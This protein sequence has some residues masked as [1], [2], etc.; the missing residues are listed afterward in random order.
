MILVFG[1]VLGSVGGACLDDNLVGVDDCDRTLAIALLTIGCSISG[2]MIVGS[3][4]WWLAVHPEFTAVHRP[5]L[6]LALVFLVP[7]LVMG[8]IGTA[9]L[10]DTLVGYDRG[11]CA[12]VLGVVLMVVGWSLSVGVI[13]ATLFFVFPQHRRALRLF[14]VGVA[15]FTLQMVGTACLQ[16]NLVGVDNCS[17]TVAIGFITV[18]SG[19]MAFILIIA[20]SLYVFRNWQGNEV[21]VVVPSL[22]LISGVGMGS[23]GWSCLVDT[24]AGGCNKAVGVVFTLVGWIAV[25]LIYLF[26]ACLRFAENPVRIAQAFIFAL[27]LILGSIGIAC[28]KDD[29]YGFTAGSSDPDGCSAGWGGRLI[30]RIG[31]RRHL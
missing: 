13:L 22:I 17:D 15:A 8:S 2:V 19:I 25:V 24:L 12:D 29:L 23:V 14:S 6:C 20:S 3:I 26:L 18:G 7:G 16:N 28:L 5:V 9:C 10:N 27:A 11:E 31:Q 1:I 4:L 30:G 21:L